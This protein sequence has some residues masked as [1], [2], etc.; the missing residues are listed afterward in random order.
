MTNQPEPP[1][2]V[3]HPLA[4][5]S[6]SVARRPMLWAA[7][8]LALVAAVAFLGWR[9]GRSEP[10]KPDDAADAKRACT[11]Q[12]V[13]AKLKAPA[14]AKFSSMEIAD[15]D[16]S[17]VTTYTVTGSVDAQNGFGALVRSRWTCIV[18]RNGDRWELDT[19]TVD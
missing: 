3:T 13:P 16:E 19:A 9:G 7:G 11:E 6:L 14:T 12:F 5:I 10:G 15:V 17:I 2:R 1:P 8:A 18:H 4:L